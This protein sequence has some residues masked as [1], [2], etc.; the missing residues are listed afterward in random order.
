M[1][2]LTQAVV[3]GAVGEACFGRKIGNKAVILGMLVGSLPDFDVFRHPFI[4]DV[5]KLHWHRGISHSL[6]LAL[7]VGLGFF[8]LAL[9]K[10]YKERLSGPIT[11]EQ[12]TN[13]LQWGIF[14]ILAIATHTLIDCF[15]I[16][17]TKIIAPVS[18]FRIA[19]GNFFLIDPFYT[20]PL[21][22]GLTG[23]FV[24][25]KNRYKRAFRNWTGIVLSSIY[26]VFSFG[27][28]SY[29]ETKLQQSLNEKEIVWSDWLTSPTPFNIF[30]WRGV[31][32]TESGYWIGYYSVLAHLFLGDPPLPR[33]CYIDRKEELIGQF[34]QSTEMA[35]L[36]WFSNGWY[37]V[38]PHEDGIRFSDIRSGEHVVQEKFPDFF[39]SW[40]LTQQNDQLVI[41]ENDIMLDD[42]PNTIKQ[43]WLN[44]IGKQDPAICRK[45]P[46]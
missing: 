26:I 2:S 18:D 7:F 41:H 20:M 36:K 32:K 28:S 19:F 9:Y 44:I 23:A 15:T 45:T 10:R 8:F 6:L 22:L 25:G 29:A 11:I 27:F 4:G 17:G 38:R 46:I 12:E 13:P 21:L 16:Y 34:S 31:A 33:F 30:L 14:G 3:G 24:A 5:A 42:Y 1:D 35:S 37:I 43:V 39:V 40:D